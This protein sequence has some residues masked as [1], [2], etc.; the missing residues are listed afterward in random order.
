MTEGEIWEASAKKMLQPLLIIDSSSTRVE[1][2]EKF[3]ELFS[4]QSRT[5]ACTYCD[6]RLRGFFFWKLATYSSKGNASQGI[7]LD[8]EV[9]PLLH[10]AYV[11]VEDCCQLD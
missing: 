7:Y 4:W 6:G 1:T 3:T 8:Q 11:V 5:Y 10:S 9:Q 2:R